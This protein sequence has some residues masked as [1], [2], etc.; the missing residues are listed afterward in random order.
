MSTD[1]A[2]TYQLPSGNWYT[3]DCEN[4]GEYIRKLLKRGINE[5]NIKVWS[6]ARTIE[7]HRY[8]NDA[9]EYALKVAKGYWYY[10]TQMGHVS[11]Y[12]I[13]GHHLIEIGGQYLSKSC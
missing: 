4:G 12:K 3:K 7:M 1:Y 5:F 8:L 13:N 9:N 6:R 11:E 10:H 2:I